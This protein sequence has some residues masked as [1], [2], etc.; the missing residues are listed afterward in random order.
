M[1]IETKIIDGSFVS[2]GKL[3]PTVVAEDDQHVEA[4][5]D[6]GNDSHVRTLRITDTTSQP[7]EVG[8]VVSLS[9]ELFSNAALVIGDAHVLMP[10]QGTANVD[11]EV[12][13]FGKARLVVGDMGQATTIEIKHTQI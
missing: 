11:I 9:H 10:E 4:V 12:E 7:G 2:E 3:T 13:R 8:G 5:I 1:V 6:G